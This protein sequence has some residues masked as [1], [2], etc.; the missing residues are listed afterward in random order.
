[1]S[2]D[3]YSLLASLYQT[4]REAVGVARRAGLPIQ[5]IDAEGA[6]ITVWSSIVLEA[7]KRNMLASLQRTIEGDYSGTEVVRA[8]GDL[9][10]S[11]P[12]KRPPGF[13]FNSPIHIGDYEKIMDMQPTFLPISFLSVGIARSRSVV[14]V[15]CG[16][17]SYGSGFLIDRNLLVTNHHVLSSSADADNARAEFGYELTDRATMRSP[18]IFK[19]TPDRGFST[20]ERD[21]WTLVRLSGDPNQEWGAIPLVPITTKVEQFV[22]VIQHPG[23]GPKQI[24]L[25]HNVVVFA[26][27]TRVQYLTDTM[28]GSSGSPVFD[29]SWQL[30]AIHHAGGWLKQPGTK[31]ALFCN[32]GIAVNVVL[33]GI[34][35]TSL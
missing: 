5:F 7:R 16:D 13:A 31:S 3:L 1:M 11:P 12:Q 30:V 21:D 33:N 32:E 2:T 10:Q 4:A 29:S 26:D 15:A 35:E 20:S 28:P 18:T 34:S 19:L 27:T 22:N 17:G 9:N 8:F 6:A 14:R 25:Y 24:A 23:G